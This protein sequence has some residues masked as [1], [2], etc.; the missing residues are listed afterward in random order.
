MILIR[1]VV[2]HNMGSFDLHNS[3]DPSM[4]LFYLTY[5]FIESMI[6]YLVI[7]QLMDDGLTYQYINIVKG[8]A[9]NK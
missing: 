1:V 5:L 7:F 3:N 4:R 9:C 6:S 8:Q 2:N